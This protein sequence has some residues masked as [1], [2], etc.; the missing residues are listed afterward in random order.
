[1]FSNVVMRSLLLAIVLIPT[2]ARADVLNMA[3]GATSLEFVAVGD[4]GNVADSNGYGAVG[5][6]F[7]IG[8]YDVTLAQYTAFLNAVAKSDPY[9]L[10]NG[11]MATD[12]ATVGIIQSGSA[13][14][15][16]YS[17][18]GTAGGAANMPVFDVSWGAAARFCNWLENGQPSGPGTAEGPGTTETGAYQINGATSDTDLRAVVRSA[19]AKYFIPTENEWYKAA[20]Y[21]GGGTNAGYWAYPTQSNVEPINALALAGTNTNGANTYLGVYTDPTNYLTPVG[22]FAA[23]HSAYGAFDMGGNI[24]Q[25]NETDVTPGS[26]RG[27][28]GGSYRNLS[29]TLQSWCSLYGQPSLNDIVVGFRVASASLP[30]P[31]PEPGTIGLLLSCVTA[32]G[33]AGFWR[34]SRRRPG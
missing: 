31:V 30:D 33:I 9:G 7:A 20:Y 13:G 28:R 21:V 19:T 6:S 4:P 25:W 1:M 2:A 5:S 8:K 32:L 24:W 12:Y 15:Y 27:L 26:F 14:N 23:T 17:V 29:F 11:H 34:R 16:N 22:T 18:V 10:Y 3:G